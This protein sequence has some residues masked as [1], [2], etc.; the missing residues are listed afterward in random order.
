MFISSF[1]SFLKNPILGNGPGSLIVKEETEEYYEAIE[2]G[3]RYLIGLGYEPNLI[4]SI[5][6]DTGIIGLLFFLLLFLSYV[7][8]NLRS[9]PRLETR[10]QIINFALFGGILGLFISYLFTHG[11]WMPFTWVFLALNIA[12]IKLAFKDNQKQLA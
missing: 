2:S 7:K 11:L 12:G 4:I 9:I 1:Q 5:L 3:H 10:F 6:N 8:F